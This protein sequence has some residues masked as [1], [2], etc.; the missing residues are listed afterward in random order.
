MCQVEAKHVTQSPSSFTHVGVKPETAHHLYRLSTTRLGVLAIPL[1]ALLACID[2]VEQIG[3]RRRQAVLFDPASPRLDAIGRQ[4]H[5]PMQLTLT[6][7][8]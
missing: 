5:C 1:L 8:S 2:G 6:T 7:R 3:R 4:E